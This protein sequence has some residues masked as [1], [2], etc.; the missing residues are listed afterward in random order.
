METKTGFFEEKEGHKSSSR[1]I[2]FI[3][4]VSA[5]LMAEQ[6]LIFA[7]L[8]GTSVLMAATSAG[9]AFI[10]IGGASMLYMY[11]QKKQELSADKENEIPKP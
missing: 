7:Y 2:A 1:L 11:N 5:L 10:T 6:I 8:Q 3:V 9:T 4:V